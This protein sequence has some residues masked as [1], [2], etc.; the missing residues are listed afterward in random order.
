[1][2]YLR[3]RAGSLMPILLACLDCG[4]LSPKS[5]CPIHERHYEKRRL[6][7]EPW[8]HFYRDPRWSRVRLQALA[9]DDGQCTFVVGHRRCLTL[10]PL[11]I[12]HTKKLRDIWAACGSPQRGAFG[13]DKFVLAGCD[14]RNLRTLCETHHKLVDN[15]NPDEKWLGVPQSQATSQHR[16]GFRHNKRTTNK[17]RLHLDPY[18]RKR[19]EDED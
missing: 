14:I 18:D 17:R 6:E 15:S 2:R 8:R 9:R 7:A 1:V 19:Q 13:W 4:E 12:H 10:V 16:R 5:R 11:S 3:A